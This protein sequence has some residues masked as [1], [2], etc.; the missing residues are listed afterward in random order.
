MTAR[1]VLFR[2]PALLLPH[3]AVVLQRAGGRWLCCCVAE[4]GA[5]VR[6]TMQEKMER[7]RLLREQRK[8]ERE[9][10][11]RRQG[12]QQAPAL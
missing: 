2:A 10:R 8:K 12:R 6:R 9:V 11:E 4:R 3:D 1:C 7:A 5:C